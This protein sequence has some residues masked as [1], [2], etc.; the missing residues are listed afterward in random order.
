MNYYEEPYYKSNYYEEEPETETESEKRDRKFTEEEE[1]EVLQEINRY[2]KDV[3]PYKNY[4]ED[5]E[6]MKGFRRLIKKDGYYSMKQ[7]HNF[8]GAMERHDEKKKLL[9]KV[10]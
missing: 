10:T 3:I 6:F 4:Y 2:L 7:L 1:K 8:F 9:H 5:V